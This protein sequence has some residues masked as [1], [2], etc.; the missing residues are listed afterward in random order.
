MRKAD[1]G[2]RRSMPWPRWLIV[3]AAAAAIA[4]GLTHRKLSET[5]SD[6]STTPTEMQ[7]ALPGPAFQPTVEN[8][9]RPKGEA[10]AGMLWIPGGE[11]SM[12]AADSPGEGTAGMQAT[13]D[14]RPIHRVYVDGFYMDRTDVTNAQ[15]AR[16]VEATHYV[17]VAERAPKAEDFPGVPRDNLVAGSIVFSPPD[18]AVPLNDY[19]QWWNYVHGANWRHPLGPGSSLAQ[20]TR[21][22]RPCRSSRLSCGISARNGRISSFAVV[23]TVIMPV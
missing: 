15:F 14:S 12:G 4:A 6:R 1:A 16:F 23:M 20:R 13:V 18:H 10:P 9:F 3:F 7:S 22:S 5:I 19:R 17:T 11:F 8:A 21:F 2:A